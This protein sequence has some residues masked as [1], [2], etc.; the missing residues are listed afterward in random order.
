[1]VLQLTQLGFVDFTTKLWRSDASGFHEEV[2]SNCFKEKL[3]FPV[4]TDRF[5]YFRYADDI[6]EPEIEPR[7]LRI[8]NQRTA[9]KYAR[10]IKRLCKNDQVRMITSCTGN[11]L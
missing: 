7:P 3:R 1:M 4:V 8:G 9:M 10:E 11:K 6:G 2:R 5:L